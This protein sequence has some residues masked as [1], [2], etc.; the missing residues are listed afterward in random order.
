[1][2]AQPGSD[3]LYQPGHGK[4]FGESALGTTLTAEMTELDLK[5]GATVTVHSMDV[6]TDW[7]I[8]EWVDDKGL[9][10]MTTIEPTIFDADFTIV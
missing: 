10:R 1:M 3:Y 9:G 4:G 8:I 2:A 7:P 6:D 5:P